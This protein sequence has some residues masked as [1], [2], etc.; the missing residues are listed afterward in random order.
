MDGKISLDKK[1]AEVRAKLVVLDL[2][3]YKNPQGK[4]VWSTKGAVD[5]VIGVNFDLRMDHPVRRDE[6]KFSNY[7]ISHYKLYLTQKG[8]QPK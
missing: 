6:L 5:G 2:H 4:W 1:L 8:N 7:V 3:I